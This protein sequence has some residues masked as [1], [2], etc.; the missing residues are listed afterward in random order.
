MSIYVHTHTHTHTHTGLIR[1]A[2]N[3][4]VLII[5]QPLPINGRSKNLVVNQSK[6][7]DVSAGLQYMLES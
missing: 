7:L 6:R 4:A 2:Y 1:I 5:Q 3:P